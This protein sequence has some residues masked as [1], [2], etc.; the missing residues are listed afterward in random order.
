MEE[1]DGVG[2]GG[3][4]GGGGTCDHFRDGWTWTRQHTGCS[5]RTEHRIYT[6][7]IQWRF[8][9]GN[10]AYDI[11]HGYNA[12]GVTSSVDHVNN[13]RS[14]EGENFNNGRERVGG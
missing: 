11:Q 4:G 14:G 12:D 7:R 9:A 3:G 13:V 1:E 2:R 5:S 8:T 6:R 10:E